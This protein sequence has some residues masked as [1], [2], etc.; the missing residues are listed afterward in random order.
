[1]RRIGRVTLLF[2]IWLWLTCD[3][4]TARAST[5]VW[6]DFGT[7]G[8]DFDAALEIAAPS[9][10]SA[11]H[12]TDIKTTVVSQLQEIYWEW[13]ITFVTSDPGG[14]RDKLDMH[15]AFNPDATPAASGLLGWAPFDPLNASGH[16]EANVVSRNFSSI[17]SGLDDAGKPVGVLA[18]E[19]ATSLAGRAAHE[20]GH[21]YGLKDQDSF[22]RGGINP[23]TYAA[24]GGLQDE[25]VMAAVG[26]GLSE[27]EQETIRS[28]F[29]YSNAKLEL[30]GS[31]GG[32]KLKDASTFAPT[33][34]IATP[35]DV[36]GLAQD[37]TPGFQM[38]EVSGLLAQTIQLAT[39]GERGTAGDLYKFTVPI[40]G[41][42]TAEVLSLDGYA[43]SVEIIL[44]LFAAD[45]S[46][47]IHFQ[48]GSNFG[49]DVYGAG[50]VGQDDPLM[51]NV[52]I[53][54]GTYFLRVLTDLAPSALT[55]DPG[56]PGGIY[57]L[58][59]TLDL[60]DEGNPEVVPEPASVVL[61]A[62]GLGI[63]L[64]VIRSSRTGRIL[65]RCATQ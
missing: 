43:D 16:N 63:V 51:I 31:S 39:I 62:I 3:I 20:L 8:S 32:I 36:L 61:F 45:G 19:M 23:S 40:S 22:G 12:K 47:V 53:T 17:V 60:E 44:T 13:D 56:A 24:T 55:S 46:T 26:T 30:T 42:I 7:A 37:I 1:M 64:L 18:L 25:H 38:L 58:L 33:T 10:F 11:S 54:A 65:S 6:V 15:E 57:D 59:V 2:S 14:L 48:D 4:S 5:V 35:H 52:P 28:F 41:H 29:S 9:L 34:E 21:T 27:T 49:L 50:S